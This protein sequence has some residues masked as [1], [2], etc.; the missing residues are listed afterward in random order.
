MITFLAA[1]AAFTVLWQGAALA[2]APVTA[3]E[4]QRAVAALGARV[5]TLKDPPPL[6]APGPTPP[7]P[8]VSVRYAA[9]VRW[10]QN[11]APKT[12]PALVTREY[13]QALERAAAVIGQRTDPAVLED[14]TRELEAKVTHCRLLGVGMGGSI[15]LK[16]NTRRAGAVVGDWQV[17]YLL[18]FDD[19]LKTPPRTFPRVSSPTDARVEPGRYWIWAR[20]PATGRT[21][22]RMLV[23]VAGRTDLLVDLPVP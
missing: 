21:S 13:V 9:A 20:D 4:L 14:V 19:W 16:V 2:Q 11:N 23:E 17:H 7:P 1:A 10:L 3:E 12:N 5:G 22:E 15:A 18:K 6:V 8:P